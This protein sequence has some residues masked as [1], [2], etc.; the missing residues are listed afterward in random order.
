MAAVSPV[1]LPMDVAPYHLSGTVYGTL[2]NQ[3]G[4]LAA[5]GTAIN[6]PPYKAAPKAVVLYVKPR[7]TLAADGADILLPADATELE[8]GANLGLV[9]GRTACRVDPA[10][11]LQH[12]AG[13]LIVND[14]SVPHLPYYRPSVRFKARDG[15]CPLGPR[16]TPRA[17]VADP[18][19]LTITVRVDGELRQSASTA[20]LIRPVA[21]L[22]AEVT[23]FMT[24]A[25]GDV[26]AVG[27]AAGAPRV[28]A[29]Q[30]VVV[31]ISGLGCLSNRIV[32]ARA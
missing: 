3:R 15:F 11:A 13:Y 18:A 9:I 4:A 19:A 29:G 8:V 24:L 32:G 21:T 23:E 27:A 28:R 30:E 5:L 10:E 1:N 25:P 14:I 31:E 26:L 7:N 12:I 17:A 16:V 2:L 22:L 6:E 20:D